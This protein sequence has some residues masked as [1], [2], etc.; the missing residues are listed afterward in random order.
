MYSRFYKDGCYLFFLCC[1]K[2]GQIGFFS[3]GQGQGSTFFF[4]L[5]LYSAAFA[6]LDSSNNNNT[7][8][9][10]LM[11]QLTE[12]AVGRK[13]QTE[14]KIATIPGNE[15]ALVDEDTNKASMR[16]SVKSQP[17]RQ[18]LKEGQ[19]R[20]GAVIYVTFDIYV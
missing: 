4:E 7:N 12:P 15:I 20:R 18:S 9:G 17:P 11:A 13:K 3:A 2:Q 8:I 16:H 1:L 14:N 6:G 19:R 5:P 10:N